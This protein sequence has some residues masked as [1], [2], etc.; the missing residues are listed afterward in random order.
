MEMTVKGF[1]GGETISLV[2]VTLVP[3]SRTSIGIVKCVHCNRRP[4]IPCDDLIGNVNFNKNLIFCIF[5]AA[6]FGWWFF[7]KGFFLNNY[8]FHQTFEIK[9]KL[10]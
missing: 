10:N 7:V 1:F 4:F 8:I 3:S 2:S 9:I 5:M 6:R